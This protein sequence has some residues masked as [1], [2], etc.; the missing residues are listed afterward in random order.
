M[1]VG[2]EDGSGYLLTLALMAVFFP[3]SMTTVKA[4]AVRSGGAAAV[5]EEPSPEVGAGSCFGN[6]APAPNGP[7]TSS[8]GKKGR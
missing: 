8:V 5:A 1:G 7:T 6:P 4:K 2:T 3:F